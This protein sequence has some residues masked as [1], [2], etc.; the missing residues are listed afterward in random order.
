MEGKAE[1]YIGKQYK[2]MTTKQAFAIPIGSI[3]IHKRY[4]KAII[5]DHIHNFGPSIIPTTLYGRLLL[6]IDSGMPDCPIN[7]LWRTATP[8]LA[9]DYKRNLQVYTEQAGGV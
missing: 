3:V 9:S 2:T 4:G 7:E 1:K 6:Q 5:Y 8:Y